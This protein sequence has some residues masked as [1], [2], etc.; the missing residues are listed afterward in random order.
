M[1]WVKFKEKWHGASFTFWEN[2]SIS[3]AKQECKKWNRF[4]NPEEHL[5]IIKSTKNKPKCIKET[6][7]PGIYRERK[8]CKER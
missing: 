8:N 7:Y 1:V 3:D 5:S 6:K 2:K 4:G